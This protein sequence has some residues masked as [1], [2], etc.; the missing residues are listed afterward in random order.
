MAVYTVLTQADIDALAVT[1][2]L[3]TPLKWHGVGAGIENSTYFLTCADSGGAISEYVLT[4]A[5]AASVADVRFIAQWMSLLASSGLP[6]PAPRPMQESCG[7]VLRIREKPAIVVPKIDGEHLL[8]PEPTHC[9]QIGRLLGAMHGI[10]LQRGEQHRSPRGLDWLR[11]TATRVLPQLDSADQ[12]LLREELA[13][14]DMLL[15]ADLPTGVIHGDLFRD[16]A[17]FRQGT[18]VA[19]IDFFMAG[20]GPLA[21]DLAIAVNDW[22]SHADLALDPIRVDAM[23]SAYV[24]ER[25]LTPDEKH[26][27]PALLCLAACRFWV[28]RLQ[29]HL[30]PRPEGDAGAIPASKDPDELRTML[31]LRRR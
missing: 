1:L 16:N 27:W 6:V 3:G 24:S 8:V 21:L 26:H 31:R 10:A 7:R 22:C 23:V 4:I 2:D 30:E 11:E 5:E 13:R 17:L 28:S 25:P 29:A 12:Q 19:V 20:S 14:L 18:L 9:A 15:A